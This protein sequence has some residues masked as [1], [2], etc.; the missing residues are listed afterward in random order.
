M[1]LH[2]RSL[3]NTLDLSTAEQATL[4]ALAETMMAHAPQ[5][6]HICDGAVMASLFFEPSTRTRLSFE[7]A[8]HRLGGAVI[9][10]SEAGSSS[11]SKG[12]SV[13]DTLKVVVNTPI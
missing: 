4:L 9:G 10:F 1:S 7:A 3:I 12:E 11:T 2:N 5:Y 8:M 13:G 6:D